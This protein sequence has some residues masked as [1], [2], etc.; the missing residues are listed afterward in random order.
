MVTSMNVAA[1]ISTLPAPPSE[2]PTA[3][4]CS[5]G[6]TY[7]RE[8]FACLEFVATWDDGVERLILR[9]CCAC[10]STISATDIEFLPSTL[11]AP[12][13]VMGEVCDVA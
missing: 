11:P 8:A 12:P 9:N 3:V 5:C 1:A 2:P 6:R 7:S 13:E 4:R 10:R